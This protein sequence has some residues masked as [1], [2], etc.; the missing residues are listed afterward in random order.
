ML[1]SGSRISSVAHQLSC[2]GVGFLL[3]LITGGLFL[4][5]VPFLWGKVSDQPASPLLSVFCDCLIIF[6]FAVSFDFRCCSLAQEM[7]FVTATCPISGSN[8][9]PACCQSFCLSR[10]CLL[11]VHKKISSLLL[12]LSLVHFQQLCPSTVC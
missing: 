7:R 3:C 9:S 8:L 5:L 4:C 2:F 10:L 6:N 1:S 12:P 11:K